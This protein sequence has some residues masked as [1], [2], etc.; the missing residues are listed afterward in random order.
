MNF[1]GAEALGFG[2][3]KVLTYVVQEEDIGAG[4][5][6]F[7]LGLWVGRQ[8]ADGVVVNYRIG[9]AHAD[10]GGG[11]KEVKDGAYVWMGICEVVATKNLVNLNR[12]EG[13]T[14]PGG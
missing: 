8:S 1:D 3:F 14:N 12:K 13:R 6:A 5:G 9:F 4:N 7:S 2:R 10:V 11:D